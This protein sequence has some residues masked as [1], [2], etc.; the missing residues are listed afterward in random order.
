MKLILGAAQFGLPYGVTRSA[1]HVTDGALQKILATAASLGVSMVDT[2]PAYGTSEARLGAA[3]PSPGLELQTKTRGGRNDLAVADAAADFEHSQ[4]LLRR[5]SFDSFLIHSVGQIFTEGGDALLRFLLD[6]KD[7]GHISRVGVSVYESVQ[8]DRVLHLFTPDVIQV[9]VSVADQRLV[10]NGTL[11]R[12]KNKGV[13][14]QAR[15]IFLQGVLL[16]KPEAL[17]DAVGF[18]AP[19]VARFRADSPQATARCF[20]FLDSTGLVD[21]VVVGV[22][23][24]AQLQEIASALKSPERG[25]AWSSFKFPNEL[26]DP[27]VWKGFA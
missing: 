24:L 18:L 13:C 3:M 26:V 9:P 14:V 22:H 16:S 10:E 1:D 12:L 7:R 8:I 2:S 4:T 19:H 5:T 6:L 23:S 17:P 25:A 27:R 15:S 21:E 11:Q 20:G